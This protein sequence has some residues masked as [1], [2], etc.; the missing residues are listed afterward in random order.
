MNFFR[1]HR[2][3]FATSLLVAVLVVVPHVAFAQGASDPVG[4]F[5]KKILWSLLIP[6]TSLFLYLGGVIFDF[7][8]NYFVVGFANMYLT[9]GVGVAV[10]KVWVI[11][12]DFMNM[13][14][15]F[16]LLYI[17]FKMI[18]DSNDSNTRRWLVNLVIA[19]VLINFSL[20]ATKLVV[21][22]SNQLAAQIAISGLRDASK[23]I[24]TTPIGTPE[25]ELATYIY[26]L[27]GIADLYNC[28]SSDGTEGC[29]AGYG[30]IFGTAIFFII[31]GFVLAAGGILLMI[32]FVALIFFMLCSPFMFISWIL[33]P[34]R[35]IMTSYW[36]KF[37]GRAFFAPL[38]FLFIYFSLEMLLG[39]QQSIG[40]GTRGKRWAMALS[41]GDGANVADATQSTI[42]FFFM[43]CA[44][45]IGSLLI[46]QKL[47]AE[48]ADKAVSLGKSISNRA[49]SAAKR[50][51]GRATFGIAGAVGQRTIGRG[52]HALSNS[53]GF[54]KWAA[55]SG[56]G[57]AALGATRGVAD[58]SFDAR[59]VG[60]MGKS[61]GI[62]E[63]KKG[64]FSSRV[65]ERKE[66]DAKFMES[67]DN[68][69]MT[70]EENKDRTAK[71]GEEKA[72][73]ATTE[74][75][76]AEAETSTVVAMRAH[77]HKEASN[78]T[79]DIDSLGTEIEALT[80]ALEKKIEE[81]TITTQEEEE[82]R[83]V[84]ADK[85]STRDSMTRARDEKLEQEVLQ[86]KIDQ[87]G[88]DAALVADP[89]LK[90]IYREKQQQLQ[91]ELESRKNLEERE[92]QAEETI[93]EADKKI[94][95]AKNEAYNEIKYEN[96]LAYLA[97][98]EREANKK[99]AT[100]GDKESFENL[101]KK[102]GKNAREMA[103]KSAKSAADKELAKQLAKIQKDSGEGDKKKEKKEDEDGD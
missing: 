40:L 17:G 73:E 78:L 34:V 7:A 43:I 54:Q 96:K 31:T 53:Q 44:F 13:L 65:K 58:S 63:G 36:K 99:Y 33:P 80:A 100:A 4:D 50:G 71:L 23:P 8:I 20:L 81:N 101:Q 55:Q 35:D 49:G 102:Y 61:M 72:A 3:M 19:A 47:G 26:Q 25:I 68:T 97:T 67:L 22:F 87:A 57:R 10:D 21:D 38:Y 51:A 27:S 15:I 103:E 39:L 77:G 46:A 2:A 91:K 56:V 70:T 79:A 1:Q 5:F 66:S 12:R 16:G 32:R 76:E 94:A 93:I 75:H 82:E 30:Y 92:K 28:K 64:G 6:I 62:G 45:M 89:T 48:G 59:R 85:T 11:L 90:A 41:G 42:P 98:A 83:K 86:D 18:L 69:D 84:I 29:R 88:Y 14:F 74:K 37:L 52:A 60:G 24:K 9:T 95:A